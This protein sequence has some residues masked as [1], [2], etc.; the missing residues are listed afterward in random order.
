M[1]HVISQGT[2]TVRAL[3]EALKRDEQR[4]SLPRDD[5]QSSLAD[6]SAPQQENNIARSYFKTKYGGVPTRD[7]NGK[8]E[9]KE[10]SGE[11][12]SRARSVGAFTSDRENRRPSFSYLSLVPADGSFP[13]R[14]QPISGPQTSRKSSVPTSAADSRA[15]SAGNQ[16][17]PS[18]PSMNVLG[19]IFDS[20]MK[21]SKQVE[22]I[23]K[24][25]NSARFAIK[26]IAKYFNKKELNDLQL[27]SNP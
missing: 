26:T 27:K 11:P 9:V 19:V 22:L 3:T 14:T 8:S 25:A 5:K 24:R 21:W 4:F 6:K 20:T 23:L 12:S 18:T 13:H 7:Q 2:E 10:W 17:V 1:E 16:T 15:P